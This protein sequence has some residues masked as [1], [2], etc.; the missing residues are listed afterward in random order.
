MIKYFINKHISISTCLKILLCLTAS[1]QCFGQKHKADSCFEAGTAALQT[2]QYRKAIELFAAS[3]Q[4]EQASQSPR[5]ED[6]YYEAYNT[7]AAYSYVQEYDSA[8]QY[9]KLSFDAIYSQ[10]R[11]TDAA[12]V[13]SAIALMNFNNNKPDSALKALNISDSLFMIDGSI[14]C[15]NYKLRGD[16][17]FSKKKL[18][19]INQLLKNDS[20]FINSCPLE[21]ESLSYKQ[22]MLVGDFDKAINSIST[23]I[24]SIPDDFKAIDK[25]DLYYQKGICEVSLNQ[26]EDALA[27]FNNAFLLFQESG[28]I[29]L[30]I[31]SLLEKTNALILLNRNNEALQYIA[32]TEQYANKASSNEALANLS[33]FKGLIYKKQ[34]NYEMASKE[35]LNAYQLFKSNGNLTNASASLNNI[36]LIYI[37][38]GRYQEAVDVFEKNLA[39]AIQ[40]NNL[41]MQADCHNNIGGIFLEWGNI[42]MAMHNFSKALTIYN[43]ANA[44]AEQLALVYNNIGSIYQKLEEWG[45]ATEYYQ[46]SYEEHLKTQNIYNQI[47]AL[48]NLGSI[49][50]NLNR[51]DSAETYYRKALG[52][53]E[54]ID[55]NSKKALIFDNIGSLYI[56]KKDYP[57]AIKLLKQSIVYRE[58]LEEKNSLINSF[59]NISIAYQ[60]K[61]EHDSSIYFLNKAISLI[62]ELRMQ[63]K[64]ENKL[65]YLNKQIFVY[66]NLIIS[67][68]DQKNYAAV[69]N[70]FE[71]SRAKYLSEQISAKNISS[72]AVSLQNFQS[73]LSEHEAVLAYASLDNK[74]I[75]IFAITA[76]SVS[77]KT[78]N[79]EDFLKNILR[80]N[81]AIKSDAIAQLNKDEIN[82]LK[83]YLEENKHIA[84]N[85]RLENKLFD[86][87]ILSYKKHLS[88]I[89]YSDVELS[90]EFGHE[91]YKLL[92]SPVE[93][94]IKNSKRLVIIPSGLLSLLPFET[95]L[96]E[97]GNY[98][99]EN[100]DIMYSNSAT[101]FS[102]L[103]ERDYTDS[104]RKAMFI[105]GISDYECTK[106][107]KS[108]NYIDIIQLQKEYFDLKSQHATNYSS[109]F[110]ELGYHSFSNLLASDIET[111][112]LQK[113][114]PNSIAI[115]NAE[116]TES[117]L[118]SLSVSNELK[119]YRNLHFSVHGIA[120]GDFPDLSSL[121]LA[122]KPEDDGFLTLEE[123]KSLKLK[124]DFVSLSACESHLGK[125]YKGEGSVGMSYAFIV[126]GAKSVSSSLWEVDESSTALFWTETYRKIFQDEMSQC[127]AINQTKREFLKGNYGFAWQLP[128]FWSPFVLYGYSR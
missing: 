102:I 72:Q 2:A 57:K 29:M 125:I 95:L 60:L 58:A 44:S 20:V 85:E 3:Y 114:L 123:I 75:S 62:E 9:F 99:I 103:K 38:K 11:H 112:A 73:Q 23:I 16:I 52:I 86:Q 37:D 53:A 65:N 78:F 92:I 88:S 28:N 49:N 18:N 22:A 127:Q 100:C 115:I 30:V 5:I 66:N 55:N 35:F 25:G 124:A 74:A 126:A 63:A 110:K 42:P 116:A 79:R 15:S 113:L 69:F 101:T 40:E 26:Y 108:D 48:N 50:A 118:K 97:K 1:S 80:K 36:A 17:L 14:N 93:S 106:Q 83:L 76:H 8:V 87:I 67:Y 39:Y 121:V 109:V 90:K 31:N 84:L 46:K 6:L 7:A 12:A 107:D 68:S 94:T 119:Q 117:K 128:F 41:S 82:T 61:N 89:T 91:L 34:G 43:K 71:K 122:C 120:N 45:L 59:N 64:G 81:I 33:N 54:R 70:T 24:E 13:Q 21:Y 10:Q 51:F 27:S 104:S 77:S 96:D 98:L 47:S 32:F 19:Q 4:Y 111:N 56:T 105:Y